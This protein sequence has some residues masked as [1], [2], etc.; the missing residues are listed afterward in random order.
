M[1]TFSRF[2][3]CY[4]YEVLM[5]FN[6]RHPRLYSALMSKR[7]RWY[8]LTAPRLDREYHSLAGDAYVYY[9]NPW[10]YWAKWRQD[11]LWLETAFAHIAKLRSPEAAA[12]ERKALRPTYTVTPHS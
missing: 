2:L 12:E 7:W 10:T 8:G 4:K 5:Y 9:L 1:S 3:I 11:D 6:Y